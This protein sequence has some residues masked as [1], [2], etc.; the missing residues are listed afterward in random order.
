MT[1]NISGYPEM[2]HQICV[3]YIYASK[4]AKNTSLHLSAIAFRYLLIESNR[5]PSHNY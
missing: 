4:L 5:I 2:W 1:L 3:M